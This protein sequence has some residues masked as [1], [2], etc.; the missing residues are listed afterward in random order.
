M[1]DTTLSP[2]QPLD[3]DGVEES[4]LDEFWRSVAAGADH[5]E[6]LRAYAEH[7]VEGRSDD[8]RQRT[9][10][11]SDANP[12]ARRVHERCWCCRSGDR[13]LVWHH[14]IQ[15]QYG[16]SNEQRNRVPLCLNCHARVHPDNPALQRTRAQRVARLKAMAEVREE[17]WPA[18]YRARFAQVFDEACRRVLE[19]ADEEVVK[20]VREKWVKVLYDLSR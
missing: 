14:V 15:L 3:P 2:A 5:L 8:W 10:A 1:V 17:Q 19:G 6:L 12:L 16:G 18:Q 20:A 13:W 9:R 4:F 11:E 7:R